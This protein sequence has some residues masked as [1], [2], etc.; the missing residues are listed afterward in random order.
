MDMISF[1]NLNTKIIVEKGWMCRL[2]CEG[3]YSSKYFTQYY[4]MYG[5]NYIS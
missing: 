4:Y 5:S 1:W 3:Q 2:V